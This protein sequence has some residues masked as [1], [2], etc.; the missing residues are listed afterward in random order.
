MLL[1]SLMLLDRK[2]KLCKLIQHQPL[3][4]LAKTIC[5][6]LTSL[7]VVFYYFAATSSTSLVESLPYLIATSEI[8][9]LFEGLQHNFFHLA[10]FTYLSDYV[11]MVYMPADKSEHEVFKSHF[12]LR[13]H[14]SNEW[15]SHFPSLVLLILI[16]LQQSSS[17]FRAHWLAS[18]Q[19]GLEE[20]DKS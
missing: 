6:H 7:P 19:N 5:V 4:W 16:F 20:V 8:G 17:P 12:V 15:S 10:A 3:K 11:H 9:L 2:S 1:W 14:E 13:H 18:D